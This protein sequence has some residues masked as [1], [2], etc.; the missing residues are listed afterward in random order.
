MRMVLAGDDAGRIDGRPD[1]L[2]SKL[3]PIKAGITAADITAA[4]GPCIENG[5]LIPYTWAGKPYL[6][7]ARTQ[8]C[9]P[10]ITSKYPWVDGS[11]RIEYVKRETRDGLKEFVLSSLSLPKGIEM[12]LASLPGAIEKPLAS[13]RPPSDPLPCGSPE[14][15]TETGTKTDADTGTKQ[16]ARRRRA[17][18]PLSPEFSISD[19]VRAWA[20][21]KGFDRLEEH[22]EAFK[23]KCQ[24]NGY[25]YVD[26]DAA[27]Q[28]AVRG[29]W[30]GLRTNRSGRSAAA[31]FS[32]TSVVARIE[33]E[34]AH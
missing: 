22:L 13:L 12:P 31:E 29:D 26:W 32:A 15:G 25:E 21:E 9:S 18:T 11:Y 2:R 20:Q 3:F 7:I 16:P 4:L 8:R 5:L 17:K 23:R 34:I 30:A 14:S 33:G 27:F 24:A 1:F 28:E 6:Q 10:C 19:R